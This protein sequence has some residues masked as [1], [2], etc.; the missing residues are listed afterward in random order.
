MRSGEI[1]LSMNIP[2]EILYAEQTN[3]RPKRLWGNYFVWRGEIL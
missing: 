2:E 3:D 1:E